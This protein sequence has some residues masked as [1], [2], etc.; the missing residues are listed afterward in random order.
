MSA[1][2]RILSV[3]CRA[4]EGT[5]PQEPDWA[6]LLALANRTLVTPALAAALHG[7]PAVPDEVQAFLT[8]IAART[9]R[10]NAMMERQ[11]AEA[12]QALSSQGV[13]PMPIKGAVVLAAHPAGGADRLFTDLDLMIAPGQATLAGMILGEI[14]YRSTAPSAAP[15]T[16]RNFE[17]SSDAGG[18]DI[19]YRLRSF[20]HWPGFAQLAPFCTEATLHG[21]SV[22]MPSPSLQ[23]AIL[24]AHDQLQE[25]DYWRGLIDLRH[26][27][28]LRAL[29]TATGPLDPATLAALFPGGR[30]RRALATQLLT[31]RRLFGI[32]AVPG[33]ETGLRP[34]LQC[35]RRF[36]QIG[37]RRTMRWLT[38][39]TL[40]LDPPAVR[41]RPDTAQNW[42]ERAQ[43]GKRMFYAPKPNKV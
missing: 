17:R 36:R 29:V 8:H 37:R 1:D 15:A 12:V 35:A 41:P 22:L 4:L 20:D 43:Y 25:R 39:A 21:A 38:A 10:R 27:L 3:L 13:V 26:V 14:G 32:E 28:D 24:I 5:V 6:A 18:L 19:H 16:G 30:A 11:L 42:R 40:L 2:R 33:L 9:V 23:A 31:L 34:R 7:N